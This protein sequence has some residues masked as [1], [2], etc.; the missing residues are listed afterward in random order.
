MK[1]GARSCKTG[2]S[3]SAHRNLL[4]FHHLC[5]SRHIDRYLHSPQEKASSNYHLPFLSSYILLVKAQPTLMRPLTGHHLSHLFPT[6]CTCSPYAYSVIAETQSEEGI[7]CFVRNAKFPVTA[8]LEAS[9][10]CAV[11]GCPFF[12]EMLV[13]LW[14]VLL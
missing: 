3:F 5:P 12:P 7:C 11:E 6:P 4:Q 8:I 10:L 9:D 1:T 14:Y 13:R 2:R